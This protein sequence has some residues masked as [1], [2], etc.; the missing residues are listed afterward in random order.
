M[1]FVLR[2][3]EGGREG[4]GIEGRRM[5]NGICIYLLRVRCDTYRGG[6]R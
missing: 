3:R 6:W 2:E 1:I 4:G 5:G